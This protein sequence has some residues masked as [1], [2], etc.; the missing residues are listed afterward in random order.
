MER[1]KPIDLENARPPRKF[2]GYDTRFV[3]S[4]LSRASKEIET[5][6]TEQKCQREEIE[7]LRRELAT[8]HAQ[9]AT[10]KE[11]LIL[12]QKAA[13]DTRSAANRESEMLIQDAR[14]K[15]AQLQQDLESK[16]NDLRWEIERLQIE[17]RRFASQFRALLEQ[18]LSGLV[19][20]PAAGSGGRAVVS[21]G[22]GAP[23]EPSGDPAA[24]ESPEAPDAAP[25]QP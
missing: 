25:V 3:D 21:P 15:A 13:D 18:Y 4:L 23:A 7:A 10:L 22:P 14:R 1:L 20:P 9:D 11:A 12:A 16:L 19:E 2:R 17:K 8:Y 6:L 24:A 5:L